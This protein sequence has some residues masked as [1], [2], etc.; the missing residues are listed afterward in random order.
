MQNKIPMPHRVARWVLVISTCGLI[1]DTCTGQ[2]AS[3]GPWRYTARKPA[4]GWQKTDFD[5]N[6]WKEGLGGF[7]DR[8]TPGARVSTD[9]TTN[10]I[11]LRRSVELAAIPKKPALYIHHDEDAEI[12]IN[13]QRVASFPG[14]VTEYQVVPLDEKSR[15]VLKKGKNLLAVHC[16]RREVASSSTCTSSTPTTFRSCR[17]PSDPRPRSSRI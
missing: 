12:F 11:W 6:A 1:A 2:T 9:W 4:D 10:N 5:D 17:L 7:G 13:G 3:D 16:A 8:S 15:S 14:Y